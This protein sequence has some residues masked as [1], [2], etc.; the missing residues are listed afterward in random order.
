MAVSTTLVREKEKVQW[1]IYHIS[2]RLLDAKTK[3]F[4][5]EKLVMALVVLSKK[6]RPYFHAHSIEVLTNYP[7]HQVLQNPETSG[8]LLK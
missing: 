5:L 1:F 2:K 4:E 6:L 7:L 3:Y 8:R